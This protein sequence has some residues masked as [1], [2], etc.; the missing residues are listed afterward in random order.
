M[1]FHTTVFGIPC[2]CK[3]LSYTEAKPMIIHGSGFGDCHPPEAEEF[4]YELLDR[5][6]YTAPWIQNKM[7]SI[8]EN[9][10]KK[11]FLS[12]VKYAESIEA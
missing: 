7:T 5:K 8:Q 1:E 4:Q 9:Q 6:G 12:K 3:V 2:I 11:E 10:L